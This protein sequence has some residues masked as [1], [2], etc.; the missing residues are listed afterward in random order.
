MAW[1]RLRGRLLVA[2][3]IAVACAGPRADEGMWTFDNVPLAAL[4]DKYNFTPPAGWLDHLRRSSVRFEDGGSG[5]FISSTGLVLTNH[6]VALDQLQ[7][8]STRENNY[9]RD[10][11]SAA[12]RDQELKSADLEVS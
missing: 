4:K 10:G 8:V 6:H 12:R 3:L 5:S 1:S 11:F 7:K 2:A 9:V